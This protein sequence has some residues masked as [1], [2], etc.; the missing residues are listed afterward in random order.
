MEFPRMACRAICIHG[1]HASRY[2][3]IAIISALE[4]NH[5][6]YETNFDYALLH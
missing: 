1:E 4:Q 2:V 3:C 5:T 6:E